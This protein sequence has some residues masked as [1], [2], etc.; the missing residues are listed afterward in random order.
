MD[1]IYTDASRHDIGVM[2]GYSFDLAFGADENDFECEIASA[3]HCCESGSYLYIE[4]T[5]YGGIVDKIAVDTAAE[6]VTYNGRTWHGI[7][8]SKVIVPLKS[9]EA[10]TPSVTIKT[11]EGGTSLVNAYLVISGDANDCIA[12]LINRIGLN[13]LF[14]VDGLAGVEINQFKFDR[15]TDAYSGIR[16][17]L[18]SVGY[19][20]SM[21]FDAVSRKTILDAVPINNYSAED[22]SADLFDFTASKKY[23]SVNHLICLG[24]GELAERTVVHLYA[25][26]DGNI[27]TTQTLFG[28]DEYVATYE[29]TADGVDEL[30]ADGAERLAELWQQDAISISVLADT[31]EYGIGDIVSASDPITN[32]TITAKISKKI[33]N[34]TDDVTTIQYE[35]GE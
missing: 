12:W 33:V 5:E 9:G 1:L 29:N 3:D 2:R 11:T 22:I 19:K 13:S 27:S 30:A 32:L 10:S 20:L 31:F 14:A 28:A 6:I 23:K 4:G 35:V 17:M 7:L 21:S 25:D 18:K 8:S 15:Y 34:I 26:A 24:A 16:K